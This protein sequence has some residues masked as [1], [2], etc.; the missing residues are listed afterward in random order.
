VGLDVGGNP[1]SDGA[2]HAIVEAVEASN[3]TLSEM[4]YLGQRRHDDRIRL[5]LDDN[6][7]VKGAFEKLQQQQQRDDGGERREE[8]EVVVTAVDPA[9]PSSTSLPAAVWRR[10]FAVAEE[11]PELLYLFLRADPV[12]ALARQFKGGTPDPRLVFC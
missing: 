4:V 9:R 12:L 2:A 10:V 7:R 3:Y 11:K 6:A 8:G 5:I 1:F